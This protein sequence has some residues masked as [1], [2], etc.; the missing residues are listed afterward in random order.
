MS[1]ARF[2]T[3]SQRMQWWMRPGPSRCWAIRNRARVEQRRVAPGGVG[4]GHRERRAQVAGQQRVQVLLLL[5]LGPGQREDLG[6]AGVRRL[7]A[8]DDR[9]ERARAE[10]LVH[11]AEL[12]LAEALP[13]QVGWEVRG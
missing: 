10:D 3:P 4:L 1:K 13:A 7:V 2:D 12:D 6:V 9:R 11:E 8:E 5:V